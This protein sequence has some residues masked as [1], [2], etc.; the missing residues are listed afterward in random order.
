MTTNCA[1]NNK[2]VIEAADWNGEK[3]ANHREGSF[4]RNETFTG[5]TLELPRCNDA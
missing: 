1:L 4:K 2:A 5:Y 3:R